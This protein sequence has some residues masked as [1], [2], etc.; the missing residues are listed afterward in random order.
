MGWDAFTD[1]VRAQY[2]G[3]TAE[4]FSWI[5]AARFNGISFAYTAEVVSDPAGLEPAWDLID[6]GGGGDTCQS[7]VQ[8]VVEKARDG[9]EEEEKEEE[10]EHD[11]FAVV[12]KLPKG[13]LLLH[14][15][16]IYNVSYEKPGSKD[17]GTAYLDKRAVAKLLKKMATPARNFASP[18][19]CNAPLFEMPPMNLLSLQPAA[20]P[21]RR[22]STLPPASPQTFR[23]TA[24]FL[25]L[26]LR[27]INTG[28]R[29]FRDRH[30]ESEYAK[31]EILRAV[32]KWAQGFEPLNLPATG[33][34][35]GT[36]WNAMLEH[37]EASRRKRQEETDVEGNADP[38]TDVEGNA[39]P[40]TD[41]EGNA[42][43][44]GS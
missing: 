4:M 14:F 44:S 29:E 35:H 25:C 11:R 26:T 38:S 42:D 34:A 15:C 23:R 24:W 20:T 8:G 19:D 43:P 7:E 10:H 41:V 39:D 17:I 31:D 16:E 1:R 13:P 12:K 30:C 27:A 21:Q 28:L 36:D 2:K 6:A 22:S 32:P 37:L 9:D 40:S 3:W 5:L 33:A 18:L